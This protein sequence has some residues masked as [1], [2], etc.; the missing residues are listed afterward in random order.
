ML[1]KTFGSIK[2]SATAHPWLISGI[3]LAAASSAIFQRP[4]PLLLLTVV[5]LIACLPL[6]TALLNS[7]APRVILA[8]TIIAGLI[9][10]QALL[11]W[12]LDVWVSTTV[13]AVATLLIVLLWLAKTGFRPTLV[14]RPWIDAAIIISCLLVGGLY[15]GKTLLPAEDNRVTIVRAVNYGMDDVTHASMFADVLRNDNNLLAGQ[16][17]RKL[18]N[19]GVHSN[20]PMGW[21]ITT[22]VIV[23]SIVG[24]QE[25]TALQ[26]LVLYFY[27]KVATLIYVVGAIGLLICMLLARLNQKLRQVPGFL[28]GTTSALFLVFVLVMPQFYE[29]FFSFL[30]ILAFTALFATLLLDRES[31]T[32]KTAILGLLAAAS[33]ATWV[34]T[35]PILLVALA[36]YLL[37]SVDSWR[38]LP[39]SAYVIW[40]ASAAASLLQLYILISADKHIVGYLASPGGITAPEHMLLII[41][42]ASFVILYVAKNKRWNEVAHQLRDLLLSFGTA[43]VLV[44]AYISLHSNEITY[45]FFKIQAVLL[46]VLTAVLL[47]VIASAVLCISDR[48]RNSVTSYTTLVIVPVLFCLLIPGVIGYGYFQNIVQRSRTYALSPSDASLIAN[49]IL[50]KLLSPENERTFFIFPNEPPRNILS[51]NTARLTYPS[52]LA[53]DYDIFNAVYTH[54]LTQLSAMLTKCTPQLPLIK[55]YTNE[56]GGHELRKAIP[57]QLINDHEVELVVI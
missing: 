23:G 38:W 52:P 6:K 16:E 33:T 30:P 39:V 10:L 19:R 53:C 50:D 21:H 46:I 18:M 44:L 24:H 15:V 35:G 56:G 31:S 1:N 13:Y 49:T 27:A 9:Q 22:G 42:I 47:A 8:I 14:V 29:G 32:T 40:G 11:F 12:A 28:V 7:V 55:I 51:S 45:Y 5:L 41:S 57:S 20:Y 2:W 3:L 48:E 25:R 37:S 54:D 17:R 43:S 4:W 34:I 26:N 36:L